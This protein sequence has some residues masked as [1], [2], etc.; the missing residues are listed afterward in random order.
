MVLVFELP[1][2]TVA[3][4][5]IIPITQEDRLINAAALLEGI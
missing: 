4:I 1:D 5:E 2:R 3:G